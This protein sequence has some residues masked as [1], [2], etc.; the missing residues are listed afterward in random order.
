MCKKNGANV[1]IAFFIDFIVYM[2][3]SKDSEI[4]ILISITA[5]LIAVSLAIHNSIANLIISLSAL[6]ISIVAFVTTIK[7]EKQTNGRKEKDNH[8]Q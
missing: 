2:S 3:M 6:A 4:A 8:K 1:P 5:V 7:K